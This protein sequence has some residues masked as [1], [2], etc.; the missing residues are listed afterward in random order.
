[1][2]I[3]SIRRNYDGL[4]MLERLSLADN[5]LS[6]D[7]DSELYAIKA[8]SPKEAYSQPD[9][10]N[11]LQEITTF[12]LCNLIS[13]LGYVM[14]FDFFFRVGIEK[15]KNF[16]EFDDVDRLFD[17]AKVAAYLY[18]RA[19]DVWNMVNDELGLR[20][21][22]DDEIGGF[23]FSVNLLKAKEAIMRK[24][25]FTEDEI[26]VCIKDETGEYK[27]QTIEDEARRIYEGLGLT[28]R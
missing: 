24:F 2:N 7:D 16:S 28:K 13:R 27:I 22:F 11:L 23:L 10:Y 17:D 18:V 9:F 1:M 12:R 19:T 14:S 15:L 8:A 20:P 21:D 26:K 4:T 25:A 3:K 6:R 5:A